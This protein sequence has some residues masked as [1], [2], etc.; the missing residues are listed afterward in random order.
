MNDGASYSLRA[1]LGRSTTYLFSSLVTQAGSLV[2]FPIYARAF[3]ASQYGLLAMVL[4]LTTVLTTL[5]AVGL[6]SAVVR[7]AANSDDAE[8]V[9]LTRTALGFVLVAGLAVTLVI[10]AFRGPIAAVLAP[11]AGT[12]LR[13]LLVYGAV[14][15]GLSAANAVLLGSAVSG[16]RAKMHLAASAVSIST[17]LA[18]A[19]VLVPVLKTGPTGAIG[20][21][22]GGVSSSLIVLAPRTLRGTLSRPVLGD[23]RAMLSFGVGFVP[24]NLSAWVLNLSDRY[25]LAHFL[26]LGLVGQYSAAY[27]VGSLVSL[28]LVVPFNA[29]YMPF[30]YRVAMTDGGPVA[31]GR[32]IRYY[33]LAG[34]GVMLTISL[35][36]PELLKVLAGAGYEDGAGLIP[37]IAAG[38][39]LVSATT[40]FSPGIVLRR[41]T[42]LSALAFSVA[43][44]ANVAANLVLIPALGMLGAAVAT[45]AA[46]A[47]LLVV[48]L[49]ISLHLYRPRLDVRRVGRAVLYLLVTGGI[50]LA[51]PLLT[52]G[53]AALLLSKLALL[54]AF[55]VLAIGYG[56]LDARES[57]ALRQGAMSMIRA[58]WPHR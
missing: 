20:S 35:F 43:A 58:S 18:L 33:L 22:I 3:G 39:F 56:G 12:Q 27:R 34:M 28:V 52:D 19:V 42:Y 55:G 14:F 13:G 41:R 44:A 21:M 26:S 57:A 2:T 23:L 46:D 10:A 5:M 17:T 51:L 15:A 54:V 50:G 36:G 25:L 49:P 9:R 30:V 16:E 48:Y 31:I 8:R 7:F 47:L 45:L 38:T 40:A 6:N 4:A 11:T 37:L 29:A 32:V 24:Q 1:L 53:W